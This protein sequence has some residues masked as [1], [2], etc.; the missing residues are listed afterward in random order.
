MLDMDIPRLRDLTVSETK[1]TAGLDAARAASA[2]YVAAKDRNAP[3][4]EIFASRWPAAHRAL[5][6]KSSID[7]G[8]SGD[9]GWGLAAIPPVIGREFL[10]YAMPYTILGRLSEARRIPFHTRASRNSSPLSFRW[11]GRGRAKPVT[12]GS[13]TTVTL[14]PLKVAGMIVL[15]DELVR[16]FTPQGERF[17]RDELRRGIVR[18]LDLALVDPALAAESSVS[19]ASILDGATSIS[20]AGG[21]PADAVEDFTSLVGLYAAAGASIEYACWL[22]SSTNA[23]ALK[24]SGQEAFRDLTKAGGFVGGIPAI[25]SEALGSNLVLFDMSQLLVADE[26]DLTIALSDVASIEMS[27]NPD[28]ESGTIVSMFQNNLIALRAERPINWQA[29]EGA[30]VYIDDADYLPGSP[31]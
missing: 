16:A 19:P 24:L 25:A 3:A 2:L 27:D 12:G 23:V 11:V 9:T 28:G 5:T 6:A 29:N 1:A 4:S 20:S 14:E 8:G 13:L 26:G 30:V 17:L 18:F 31:A 10:A 21:T 15:A 7:A 22:M